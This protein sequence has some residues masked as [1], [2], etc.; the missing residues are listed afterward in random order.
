MEALIMAGGKGTRM[1]QHNIE[2]PMTV[3]NDRPIVMGVVEALTKSK[4]ISRVLVSVSS[5]TPDTERYLQDRG[6]ETIHTSGEDYVDDLHVA[7]KTMNGQYV[8][9]IPS[10]LP[11]IR[12]YTIDAFY[13]FFDNKKEDSIIAVVDKDT[14]I[15]TGIQPSF[16]Q[17]I[18]G[19][20][21]VISGLSIMNR[22]KIIEGA[23]LDEYYFKTDWVDL[24]INVN[25]VYE[26]QLIKQFFED[27]P[28]ADD[29]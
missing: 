27:D 6:V 8:M 26:V 24:A 16:T 20:D 9:S 29:I 3:I 18:D 23:Y 14:V 2:K 4:N 10:D 1:G 28:G 5:N 25:T 17:D 22:E 7:L 13:D 12:T 11:L 15:N 21:W 19:T